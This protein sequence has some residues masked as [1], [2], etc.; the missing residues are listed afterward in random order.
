VFFI[1][2]LAVGL[3]NISN[4]HLDLAPL[5]T[6]EIHISTTFNNGIKLTDNNY[7]SSLLIYSSL[8]PLN[9]IDYGYVNRT[10]SVYPDS[11]ETWY[12]NLK[13]GSVVNVTGCNTYDI[14]FYVFVGDD[15]YNTWVDDY[16]AQTYAIRN[17]YSA[18]SCPNSSNPIIIPPIITSRTD[19]YYFV[20]SNPA[21]ASSSPVITTFSLLRME[22]NTTI[23]YLRTCDARPSCSLSLTYNSGEFGLIQAGNSANVDDDVSVS[24][25]S[26][27]NLDFYFEVFGTLT[28]FFCFAPCVCYCFARKCKTSS[29]YQVLQAD[30]S[31]PSAIPVADPT[32]S[33]PTYA[34][35]AQPIPYSTPQIVDGY[36]S[37]PYSAPPY[38]GAPGGPPNPS[39]GYPAQPMEAPPPP[40]APGTL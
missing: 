26:Q 20:W 39:M 21:L 27:S 6:A 19:N 35:P 12:W 25:T 29:D 1:T 13:P 38:G 34:Q 5:A 16:Y 3:A 23:G 30:A 15:N 24:W 36:S 33:Q 17:Y 2:G 7:V 9:V 31:I 4:H 11:F 28:L 8:P 14:E 18:G 40:Y 10:V 22:Y 32:Y 37:Q